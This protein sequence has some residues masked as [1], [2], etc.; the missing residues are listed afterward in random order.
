V[1]VSL[2]AIAWIALA[3]V[4]RQSAYGTPGPSNTAG[5][6]GLFGVAWLIVAALAW[7]A[8]KLFWPRRLP[9]LVRRVPAAAVAVLLFGVEFIVL[10][11]FWLPAAH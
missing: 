10:I 11:G 3:V 5:I 2:V 9:R 4:D 7:Q 1:V 8:L 6:D